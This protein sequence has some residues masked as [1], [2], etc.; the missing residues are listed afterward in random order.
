MRAAGVLLEAFTAVK[1]E[2][3]GSWHDARIGHVTPRKLP[4]LEHYKHPKMQKGAAPLF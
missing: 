2:R 4:R 3:D 1:L